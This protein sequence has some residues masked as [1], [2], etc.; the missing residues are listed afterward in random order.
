MKTAI[1]T[2]ATGDYL[3]GARVLFKSLEHHGL[4]SWVDRFI[5]GP[6]SC[7][8][9]EPV[10]MADD[11]S[12]ISAPN[13]KN[14]DSLKNF[15][16]LTMAYDRVISFNADM[17]CVGDPSYLWSERI[18]ALPLYA[19]LDTAAQT[20]YPGNLRRLE[21]NPLL[22]FNAGL[23]VYN[24]DRLPELHETM[25]REIAEGRVQTYEIGDQGFWN[26]FFQRH[27]LE[28]GLLPSGLNYCLDRYMPQLPPAHQRIIHFTGHKPWRWIASPS[29]WVYPYY[30]AWQAER[31]KGD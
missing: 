25:M 28:I 4:P 23:Y 15:Y 22:I 3:E 29:D 14:R 17:L 18:G 2:V 5:I 10:K 12:W 31:D 26:H 20:Y 11:Y 21:L 8:F 9:A 19:A 27:G 24:R 6:D 16:P 13:L 7:T 1:V 30:Q